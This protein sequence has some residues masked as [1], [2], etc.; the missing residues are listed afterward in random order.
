MERA[1][2]TRRFVVHHQ[3]IDGMKDAEIIYAT[4]REEAYQIAS[5]RGF[6]ILYV[7]EW[8]HPLLRP[9]RKSYRQDDKDKR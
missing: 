2:G 6:R 9:V 4:T 5:Y 3:R 1:P 7:E 8:T